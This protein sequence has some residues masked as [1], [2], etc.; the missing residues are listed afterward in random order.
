[1]KCVKCRKTIDD[2]D[3]FCGY[4][5]IN[6]KKFSAYITKVEKN[7]HKTRDAEYNK[8]VKYAQDNLQQLEQAKLKEIE[9]ITQS[10]WTKLSDNASY[11]M[12]EGKISI[13]N[14]IYLF[15][16]IKGA[17]VITRDSYRVETTETSQSKK[18]VSVGKAVVGGALLGPLGAIAGGAMGKTT[19]SG[20]AIANSIPTCTH[21]GVNVDINGF[22]T[23]IVVLNQ[24]VDQS[25]SI[26]SSKMSSAQSIVDTLRKLS[27]T[28]VPKNY[29]KPEEEQSVLDFDPKIKQAEKELQEAVD[30]KPTYEI[31]ESYYK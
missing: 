15:S 6:Q 1:M 12:T 4:C 31:P 18:H 19:S 11:N 5:G 21:I 28:P 23:E 25:S 13:N 24:T 14:D 27:T 9:R 10:R 3:L 22:G 2:D 20:Q 17:D 16:D 29:L 7:I 30:N 8:S 26:Y